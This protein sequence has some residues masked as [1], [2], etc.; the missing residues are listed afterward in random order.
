MPERDERTGLA[1]PDRMAAG[2]RQDRHAPLAPPLAVELARL[3]AEYC[4]KPLPK[5][6][7]ELKLKLGV[8]IPEI[9]K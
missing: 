8:G 4:D 6:S 2:M 3:E 1:L 7:D 5:L 9:S